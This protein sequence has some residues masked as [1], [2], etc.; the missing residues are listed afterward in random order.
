MAKK[1]LKSLLG[2]S[3]EREQVELNLD[4]TQFRAPRVQAGQ[5]S[6]RVQQPPRTNL[7]GQL[8]N[9]LGRYAGPIARQY[10]NIETQRQEEFAEIAG[11]FTPEQAAAIQGGDTTEV[12]ESLDKTIN[13]LDSKQRKKALKFVE[14]PANYV[15]GSRVLGQKL[16][17][18]YGM[19]VQQNEDTYINSEEDLNNLIKNTRD[20]VIKNNNLTGY[21]LEG[22]LEAA[23]SYDARKLPQL[24]SKRDELTETNYITNSIDA[25]VG[26]TELVEDGNFDR[27]GAEFS[28]KFKAYTPAEQSKYLE[29]FLDRILTKGEYA[30]AEEFVSW[31]ATD[32]D[33]LRLGQDA[34]LPEGTFN[35]LNE[36]IEAHRLSRETHEKNVLASLQAKND[37]AIQLSVAALSEGKAPENFTLNFGP[38]SQVEV[39]LEGVENKQQLLERTRSAIYSADLEP[40]A[41]KGAMY[42]T[43]TTQI[44]GIQ[45]DE[46]NRSGFQVREEGH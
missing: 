5:Y 32:E 16:A 20:D 41:N 22:F 31:L 25:L 9:S 4:D 37:E 28:E 17:V 13:A 39:N 3:D 46:V 36:K 18:T 7:A 33:G 12:Q 10:Q 42:A 45:T 40:E 35:I 43:L 24:Q 30:S 44:E 38:E 23:N 6:V 27:I 15:R 19:D 11:L 14:N 1:T 29:T 2:S 34:A 8:A 26:E 21:A